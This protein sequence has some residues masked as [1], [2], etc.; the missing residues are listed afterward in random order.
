MSCIAILLIFS[1]IEYFSI[2]CMENISKNIRF[3]M[4]IFK[5]QHVG[6]WLLIGLVF[7]ALFVGIIL[8]RKVYLKK[9]YTLYRFLQQNI[10]L[11]LITSTF[12]FVF[13]EVV[14]SLTKQSFTANSI[15][16][17]AMWSKIC[18]L[19]SYIAIVGI[20]VFALWMNHNWINK[21]NWYIFLSLL[22]P[23]IYVQQIL[24]DNISL[25]IGRAHV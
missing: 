22:G 2:A 5:C 23:L 10:C 1:V 24:T 4:A 20:I 19:I 8:L 3:S 14:L 12:L 18:Y 13:I 16:G 9:E 6:D 17:I 11:M 25:E 7:I 21:N 15:K